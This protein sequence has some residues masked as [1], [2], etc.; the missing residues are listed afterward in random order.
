MRVLIWL[1]VLVILLGLPGQSLAE[2]G[3]FGKKR[4]SVG[5]GYLRPGDEFVR[6]FDSSG[7]FFRGGIGLPLMERLDFAASF[8]QTKLSNSGVSLDATSVVGSILY[9]FETTGSAT[10]AV[11]IGGAFVDAK[12]EAGLESESESEVG[13][14]AGIGLEAEISESALLNAE[15]SF[16]RIAGT[17]DVEVSGGPLFWLGHSALFGATVGYA[18]DE[19]DVVIG[20]S[21]GFV[22]E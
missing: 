14:F 3:L 12:V 16:T 13:F 15:A 2:G 7:F 9:H 22:F 5:A 11:A 6:E 17:S 19:G 4:I 10:P 21:I 8:G 1:T 20:A 18:F